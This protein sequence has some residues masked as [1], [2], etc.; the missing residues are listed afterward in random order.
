M[1]VLRTGGR[2]VSAAPPNRIVASLLDL[3]GAVNV[4]SKLSKVALACS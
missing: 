4:I 1:E 3:C 2:L